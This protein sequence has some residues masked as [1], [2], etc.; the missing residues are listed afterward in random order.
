MIV[1]SLI[2]I[3]EVTK[4]FTFFYYSYGENM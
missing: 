2:L 1:S 4:T 3:G